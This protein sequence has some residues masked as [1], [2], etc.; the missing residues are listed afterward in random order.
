MTDRELLLA[1][2]QIRALALTGGRTL[3]VGTREALYAAADYLRARQLQ[4]RE[5]Q[6]VAYAHPTR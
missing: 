6:E 3:S 1:I 4:Q 5:T 2:L